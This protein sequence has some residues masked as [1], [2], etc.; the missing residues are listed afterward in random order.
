M[1]D[2]EKLEAYQIVRLQ[3]QKVM[4]FLAGQT[5]LDSQL[6][7]QWKKAALGALLNLAEGTGRM[8]NQDKKHFYTI[9]RSSV[10]ECVALLQ[11]IKDMGGVD[12]ERYTDL[13]NGYERISKMLLAM[14]RS[15]NNP[16]TDYPHHSDTSSSYPDPKPI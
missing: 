8:S 10:F 3:T 12:E 6:I 4:E 15:F 11:L 16:R 1:F 5:G 9:A 2:F 7:E 14:Y 13:Y